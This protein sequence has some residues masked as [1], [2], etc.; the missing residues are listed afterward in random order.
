MAREAVV[1]A[2]RRAAGGGETAEE[3]KKERADGAVLF[4]CAYFHHSL[5]KLSPKQPPAQ[6]KRGAA[7]W[8]ADPR[9][10]MR[11]EMR[12]IEKTRP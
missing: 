6:E 10:R 4:V 5:P 11:A 7:A 8:R 2:E 1:L 9:R 12:R 3:R